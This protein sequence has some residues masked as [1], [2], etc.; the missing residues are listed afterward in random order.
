MVN[1]VNFLKDLMVIQMIKIT[2]HLNDEG[3]EILGI[4][5]DFATYCERFGDVVK[6]EVENKPKVYEQVRFKE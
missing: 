6:V 5:E 2:I 3:Q 4:K 1:G